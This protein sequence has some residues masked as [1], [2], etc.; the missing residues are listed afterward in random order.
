GFVLLIACSNVAS[1]FLAR[2]MARQKEIAIRLAIGASRGRII[3]QVLIESVLLF[4]LGG[5]AGVL[6]AVWSPRLLLSFK[7]VSMDVPFSLDLGLDI[8]V[9]GFT[10]LVSLVT[11]VVFGLSPALGASRADIL[12]ALKSD[13]PGGSAHRSRARNAFVIAQVAVSLVLLI[14]AGLFLKSL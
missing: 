12:T 13:S 7:P 8:R 3:R 6:I 14:G 11:G 2:T 1:M 5:G 9:L 4:L 10:L